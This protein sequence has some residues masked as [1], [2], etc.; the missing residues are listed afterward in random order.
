LEDE[1]ISE[2]STTEK[3]DHIAEKASEKSAK[4][5]QKYDKENSIIFSK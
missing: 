3:I 1:V 4:A 2:A 5:E